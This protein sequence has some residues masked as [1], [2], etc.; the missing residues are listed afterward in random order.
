MLIVERRVL[1]SIRIGN[2][3]RV[4]LV[5]VPSRNRA[6]IGLEV[7]PGMPIWRSDSCPEESADPGV[8]V[9]NTLRVMLVEDDPIHARLVSKALDQ[10]GAVDTTHFPTGEEGLSFLERVAHEPD[11]RPH[12]ILHDLTLPG[13]SGLEVLGAIKANPHLKSVP[14]VM[15]S[16][17]DNDADIQ[18]C[19]NAGANAFVTKAHDYDEL[20]R[21]IFR[22]ANFWRHTQQPRAE[23]R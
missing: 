12:L 9:D 6:R 17:S 22:I 11:L 19:L 1:E 7:P 16:C 3:I 15:L 18:T 5:D 4:V 13:I 2:D 23:A 14:V 8:V 21:S 10:A 20:R